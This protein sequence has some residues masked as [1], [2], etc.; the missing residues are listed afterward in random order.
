[1][2]SSIKQQGGKKEKENEYTNVI[3]CTPAML[4]GPYNKKLRRS[5]IVMLN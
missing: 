4:K 2:K 5:D 3:K 1:M